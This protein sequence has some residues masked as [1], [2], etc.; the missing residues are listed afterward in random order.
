MTGRGIAF[1]MTAALAAL[2]AAA[3]AA[4]WWC[5]PS[6]GDPLSHLPVADAPLAVALESE[7]RDGGRVWRRLAVDGGRLGRARLLVSLP[8]PPPAGPVP[9]Q[10]VL[11]GLRTGENSIRHVARPGGNALVGFGYPIERRPGNILAIA[12]KAPR[13]R[14]QVFATPGLAAA[15]LAWTRGQGWADPARVTPVGVSL[16]AIFLPAVLR[17]DR[18]GGGAV[19][20]AVMAYGGAGLDLLAA[21]WLGAPRPLGWLAA[22][23]LAPAAPEAHLPLLAG[24]FLVVGGEGWDALVPREAAL[25]LVALTPPPKTVLIL[26]GGHVGGETEVTRRLAEAAGAWL[27]ERAALLP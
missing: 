7:E 1:A 19:G 21:H 3:A 16:G 14:A 13:L 5:W 26:P 17:L 24:P 22:L 4:L 20:P 27:A 15:A 2:P 10:F 18:A 6:L 9:V 11:G 23:G 12:A 8:D 25:R